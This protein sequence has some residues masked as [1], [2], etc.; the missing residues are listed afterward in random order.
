[1]KLKGINSSAFTTS[2]LHCKTESKK[3]NEAQGLGD[4]TGKVDQSKY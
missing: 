3:E 2:D 1:M 4:S